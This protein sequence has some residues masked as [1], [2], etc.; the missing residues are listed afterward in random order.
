MFG[1][2]LRDRGGHRQQRQGGDQDNEDDSA[3]HNGSFRNYQSAACLRISP[4][5][6][7]SASVGFASAASASLAA[8]A[9]FFPSDFFPSFCSIRAFSHSVRVF[10][11]TASA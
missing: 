3:G 5:K 10:S 11:F 4:A 8:S 7:L 2:L 9:L 1:V 6:S